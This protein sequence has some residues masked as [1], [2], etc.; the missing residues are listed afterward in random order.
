MGTSHPVQPSAVNA[1]PLEQN[2]YAQQYAAGALSQ[3]VHPVEAARAAQALS[4]EQP[5]QLAMF[6]APIV[7]PD[8][9]L[10][11]SIVVP[12]S[13]PAPSVSFVTA[14]VQAPPPS[15]PEIKQAAPQPAP[16]PAPKAITTTTTTTASQVQMYSVAQPVSQVSLVAP[17]PATA[18]FIMAPVSR[19]E[20]PVQAVNIVPVQAMSVAPVQAVSVVPVQAL[21][22]I[23]VPSGSMVDMYGN[24][25]WRFGGKG[26]EAP[27]GHVV[28]G[29]TDVYGN[30]RR[31]LRETV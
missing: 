8:V 28:L 26:S 27:T 18:S 19:V 30:A 22:A 23:Q 13:L 29:Q 4:V 7:A 24:R 12:A 15:I 31:D 2:P 16:H 6:Q 10:H 25:V 3:A 11:N 14:P 5:P 9:P 1:V 20:L 17:P 21:S